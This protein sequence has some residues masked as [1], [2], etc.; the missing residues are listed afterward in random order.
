MRYDKKNIGANIYPPL[1][2]LIMVPYYRLLTTILPV[3]V[4]P[5]SKVTFT[6]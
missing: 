4:F 5:S 2:K 3:T 1:Q 6:K